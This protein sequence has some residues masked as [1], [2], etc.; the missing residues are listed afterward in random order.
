[1]MMPEHVVTRTAVPHG[2]P[3]DLVGRLRGDGEAADDVTPPTA[4]WGASLDAGFQ[5]LP[6]A[7]LRHILKI[8]D[9]NATDVVV[10]LHLTMAWWFPERMPF[11]RVSTIAHRMGVATRT[12]Q[13]S[14]QRLRRAGLVRW[15]A[16]VT[17]GTARRVYDL[18]PLAER[19]QAWAAQDL[20]LQLQHR[21]A[22]RRGEERR[23]Q[24]SPRVRSTADR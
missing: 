15:A 10:L 7:L 4:K 23:P 9:L 5:V 24:T 19:V 2:I 17:E 1:M 11:P 16:Q 3:T 21:P 20:E 8:K 18:T 6:D 13:R 22:A 12:V 14:M